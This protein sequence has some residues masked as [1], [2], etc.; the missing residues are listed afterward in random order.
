MWVRL[1]ISIRRY[2][3]AKGKA[4]G[5]CRAGAQ[6]GVRGTGL[7]QQTVGTN[8]SHPKPAHGSH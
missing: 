2:V 1:P 6:C 8:R 4:G 3:S 7:L 5:C